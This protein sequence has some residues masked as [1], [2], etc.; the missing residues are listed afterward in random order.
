[1]AITARF[2]TPDTA[3]PPITSVQVGNAE[4]EGAATSLARSD[5]QHAVADGIPVAV[6]TTNSAGTA[7]TFAR[8]DHVHE[9]AAP[10]TTAV[11]VVTAV[12]VG[13]VAV[14]GSAASLS[15]SDHEHTVTPGVPVSVGTAN[16][17]GAARTFARSDHVHAGLTLSSTPPTDVMRAPSSAGVATD[18]ARRDHRHNINTAAPPVTSVVI[19]NAPADGVALSLSRSDHRHAV[20]SGIPVAIGTTNSAGE[21]TTF[22]RSDHVH[23]GPVPSSEM[24]VD[25]TKAPASAG[26]SIEAS[27]Q[28]HKHDVATAAPLP[29]LIGNTVDEG[30]ATNLA[31]S[32]H[33]HAVAAGIPVTIGVANLEGEAFTFARS[34]HVHAGVAFS[35][36]T[37]TAV[38]KSPANS[39]VAVEASRYDHKHDV[40]TTAPNA[41]QIGCMAAEGEAVSLSR[42][43]H[44]H[45]VAAG[46]PISV[47]A[48][49][50][51]GRATTFA[52]S[53][54]AHAGLA[55]NAN[56]YATFAVKTVLAPADSVLI[57]DSEALGVKKQVALTNLLN[58]I[59]S[60]IAP[61][62]VT[63]DAAAAGTAADAA[64]QD[65]KHD[66]ATAAPVADAVQIG[67]IATE[68]G[69][70]SLSRSDHVHTVSG[71]SPVGVG[72]TNTGGTATTFARSDHVHSGLTRGANDF[73]AFAEKANPVAA[74]VLLLEDSAAFGA[75]K[76]ATI[77]S[78]ILGC[79]VEQWVSVPATSSSAG[80]K[81]SMA[82][83]GVYLYFCT[84]TNTWM[85]FAAAGSF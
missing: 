46:F 67:N 37:P 58:A 82:T 81:G 48:E 55:R 41:V 9:G 32:D 56:D 17:E 5:H 83:D 6:G 74:D 76:R 36:E 4:A 71:G 28:D 27:R 35:S 59:L 25:V 11:P 8:S 33:Q 65:H 22:A 29:I 51:E 13:N 23:A 45:A 39:G 77:Q 12:R 18:A 24:P 49:N 16:A 85:R 26:L 30:T 14:E 61:S 1:M 19:G 69:A 63:K 3:A 84:A 20:T 40:A 62:S 75:K 66:V 79:A 44:Q 31:R 50:A 2:D 38:T 47:T 60:D 80:V 34:D 42:S 57:E 52:R 64:R 43:D 53:D 10:V 68:G 70:T 73:S 78:I 72:T 15:R 7:S 54:H 21:A